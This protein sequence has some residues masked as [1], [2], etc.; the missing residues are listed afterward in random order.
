M[1]FDLAIWFARLSGRV[2]IVQANP[3][4]IQAVLWCCCAHINVR[5]KLGFG[6]MHRTGAKI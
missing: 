4:I 5:A 2:Q 6:V 1:E 3:G